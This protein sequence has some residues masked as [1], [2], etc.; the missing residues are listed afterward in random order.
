MSQRELG[1]AK[2]KVLATEE[3]EWKEKGKEKQAKRSDK[4]KETSI[5]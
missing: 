3:M 1:K 4:D 5:N 2:E